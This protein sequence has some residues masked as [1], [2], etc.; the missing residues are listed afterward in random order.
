MFNGW[1]DGHDSN[2]IFHFF[3]NIQDKVRDSFID[4]HHVCTNVCLIDRR[5][6]ARAKLYKLV[7]VKLYKPDLIG[8]IGLL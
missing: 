4:F 5:L 3:L 8:Y 7:V 1:C 6:I 2:K